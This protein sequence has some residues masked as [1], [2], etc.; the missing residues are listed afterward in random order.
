[1]TMSLRR[2]RARDNSDHVNAGLRDVTRAALGR[3]MPIPYGDVTDPGPVSAGPRGIR[4]RVFGADSSG[5]RRPRHRL[6]ASCLLLVLAAVSGFPVY[7]QP[8]IDP[9]RHA[10]AV[11]VLGGFGENRYQF[12]L[13]LAKQGWAPNLVVSNPKGASDV[14]ERNFCTSPPARVVVHCFVPD[15]PTTKGEGRELRRLA[16]EHGWHTVIVVTFR[17]HISRAR[18]ILEQCFDGDLVMQASP[19]PVPVPRWVYEYFYQTAGYA[20]AALQ[21]GC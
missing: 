8:Q 2:A 6:L 21:P 13:D 10:D 12:G 16:S 18:F 3:I 11:L 14:W 4:R 7:V 1:M 5:K 9:L 15:P 17:A 20:R 19:D